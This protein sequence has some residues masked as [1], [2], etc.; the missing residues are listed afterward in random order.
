MK[1]TELGRDYIILNEENLKNEALLKIPRVHI[2]EMAFDEPTKDKID[3]IFT[4][5][6]KTNRFVISNNIKFYN[7]ILKTT[8]KK[9]YVKN[10]KGAGLISFFRKNNKVLL[11]TSILDETE[12]GFILGCCLADLLKNIEVIKILK[13]DF[14][15]YKSLLEVWDGNVIIV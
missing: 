6:N 15:R 13:V 14:E 1:I 3:A 10:I 2:I 11:D 4:L 12:R 8:S 9:Y 7:D 5:Y